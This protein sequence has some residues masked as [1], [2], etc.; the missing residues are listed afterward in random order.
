MRISAFAEKVGVH[1]S[2]IRRYEKAGLF[3]ARRDRQGH[4]RFGPEDV[5]HFNKIFLPE[6]PATGGIRL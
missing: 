4:R 1:P 6:Q 3:H 2:T 5:E